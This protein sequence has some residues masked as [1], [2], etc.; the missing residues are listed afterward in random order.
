MADETAPLLRIVR[1]GPTDEELAAVVVALATRAA[2]AQHPAPRSLWRN[3][4]RNIRPAVSPSPG[5]WRA[6]GLPR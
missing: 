2:A 1:G 3:R 6:S 4:S 5:A